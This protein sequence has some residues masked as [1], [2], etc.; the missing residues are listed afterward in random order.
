M[1]SVFREQLYLRLSLLFSYVFPDILTE[2]EVWMLI[3]KHT[4]PVSIYL[5]VQ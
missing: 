1:A 5:A 3:E 2:L 4:I